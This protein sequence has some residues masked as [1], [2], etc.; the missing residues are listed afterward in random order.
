MPESETADNSALE[1]TPPLSPWCTSGQ[2]WPSSDGP[3]YRASSRLMSLLQTCQQRTPRPFLRTTTP[4]GPVGWTFSASRYL[5]RDRGGHPPNPTRD[6]LRSGR[7][8]HGSRSSPPP[9]AGKGAAKAP[10]ER[11]DLRLVRGGHAIC[12]TQR[13][14]DLRP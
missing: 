12:A 6:H 9:L 10:A 8:S 2:Y 11:P 3:V 5:D 13:A 7:L 4:L 1:Y 14:R